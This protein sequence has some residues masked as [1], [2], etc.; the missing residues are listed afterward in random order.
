MEHA[1]AAGVAVLLWWVSTGAILILCALPRRTFAWSMAAA[2]LVLAAS[3]YGIAT[4]AADTS[5]SAAYLSF[6][7]ALGAWG[8]IEM[9]FLFGFVTGPRTL[10]CPASAEGWQRFNLAT[11]TVLHHEIAIVVGAA[12]L[13]AVTWGAPNQTGTLTFLVLM[14][15]R[16][17]AKLNIFLGVPNLTDAFMPA[18]LA[19]L[20]TYFRKRPFNALAP[21]SLGGGA[22]LAVMFWNQAVSAEPGSGAA[23]GGMLLFALTALAV[24][25][26]LFM[27]LPVRDD[28]LWRWAMP[29]P[30]TMPQDDN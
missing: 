8:W 26:H 6:A 23:V 14:L 24:V 4:L 27:L 2:T 18:H 9:S 1:I 15:M 10:P 12:L 19:H 17:S 16:L 22:V 11:Q 25:E 7:C 29:R 30:R 20:K 5:A 28:L 21:L 13:V 3:I